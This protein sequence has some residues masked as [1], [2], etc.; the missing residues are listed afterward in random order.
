MT[1]LR[2]VPNLAT[3][4]PAGLAAFYRDLLGL[5]PLMEMAFIS[6]LGAPNE[7]PVQLSL[8]AEGGSGTALPAISVEVDDLNDTLA[9][10]RNLGAAIEYGPVDEPWG[11]QRFFLRDPAGT[12]VN[13]LTHS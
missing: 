2:I 7:A 9:R 11:V 1:V 13:I 3:P 12:L 5:E 4:D 6:T 10:A 8:A